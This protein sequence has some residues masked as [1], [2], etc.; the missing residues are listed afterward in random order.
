MADLGLIDDLWF[1]RTKLEEKKRSLVDLIKASFGGDRSAAGRYAAEQ[2]W[3]NR[4][5]TKPKASFDLM[6]NEQ[7]NLLW[8][9]AR[10]VESEADLSNE[11][12][13][14]AGTWGTSSYMQINQILRGHELDDRNWVPE[15]ITPQQAAQHLKDEYDKLTV[16]LPQN[17]KVFRGIAYESE[18]PPFE[19]GTVFTDKGLVS[20]SV[21][22]QFA[23]GF[24]DGSDVDL[25]MEI[26]IPKGSEVWLP[27]TAYVKEEKE[28]TLRPETKFRVKEVSEDEDS[29]G[30]MTR[31]VLEVIDE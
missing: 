31:V 30:R 4:A 29:Y 28:I 18:L 14:A 10:Q 26:H 17:T 22:P 1:D 20:T 8:Q 6:N 13:K 12:K 27:Q 9:K 15:T 5:K 19:E 25:F 23:R 21:D 7:F 16:A 3:K 2:R 24:G 11:A